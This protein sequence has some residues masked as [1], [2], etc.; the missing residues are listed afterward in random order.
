MT[1]YKNNTV[2]MQVFRSV[3]VSILQRIKE[4]IGIGFFSQKCSFCISYGSKYISAGMVK[5]ATFVLNY[6]ARPN[7]AALSLL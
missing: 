6:N 5:Q 3:Q 1:S 2:L 7:E 4:G